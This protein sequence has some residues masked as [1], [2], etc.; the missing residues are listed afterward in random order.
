MRRRDFVAAAIG[1]AVTKQVY[2]QTS[3]DPAKLAILRAGT[4]P[5]VDLAD[6]LT[7]LQQLG[8]VA[9]RNLRVQSRFAENQLERLPNLAAELVTW[10]PDVIYTHTSNGAHA[11]AGATKIIPI[12]VAP[13]GERVLLELAGNLARPVAN[14]T[15]LTLEGSGQYEKC[16]Q[17]LKEIAPSARQIAVLVNPDNSG[18]SDYPAIFDA[19]AKS[20]GLILRRVESRGEADIDQ[21]LAEL[22][23]NRVDALLIANDASFFGNRSQI[24]SRIA[25]FAG[26]RRLPTAS[27][28]IQYAKEG[29]LLSFGTDRHFFHVRAAEY[30]R[31]IIEGARPGDL[32][33]ERP[34]RFSLTINLATAKALGLRVPL[35]LLGLADEV[36]E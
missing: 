14:V 19:A 3:S 1:L 33:I 8:Y 35:S 30:V 36:I 15:G 20:L 9:D 27:T 24:A 5:S 18:W 17:L 29:G 6:F 28:A 12:V 11:A 32:P 2:A 31:R 26:S 4:S 23:Q 25:G 16:L 10:Q 7:A 22:D 34:T 21:T 13:A